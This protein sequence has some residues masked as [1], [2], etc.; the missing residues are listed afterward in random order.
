MV[1]VP[2]G[3]LVVAAIAVLA[4]STLRIN[5]SSNSTFWEFKL[6]SKIPKLFEWVRLRLFYVKIII[7]FDTLLSSNKN[8]IISENIFAFG[9]TYSDEGSM[10]CPNLYK[11]LV[12]SF[13]GSLR[14]LVGGVGYAEIS[15]VAS[16]A[17]ISIS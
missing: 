15:T 17:L 2:L 8:T 10:L 1:V 5:Q 7:L 6:V 13:G 9:E 12:S 11:L 14:R 4:R 3:I 16:A